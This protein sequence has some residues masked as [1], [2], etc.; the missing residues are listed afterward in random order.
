[1]KKLLISLL[2]ISAMLLCACGG[3]NSKETTAHDTTAKVPE[4]AD[5][6]ETVCDFSTVEVSGYV[7]ATVGET[8]KG[9]ED[10]AGAD[11]YQLQKPEI[12]SITGDKSLEIKSRGVTLVGYAKEGKTAA[13][14]LCAF[15][16]GEGPDRTAGEPQLFE[17]GD[18]FMHTAPIGGVEYLSID[19]RV[20]DVGNAPMLSFK[21]SGYAVVTCANASR[22]FLYSF[23]VY[24]RD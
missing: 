22:P 18:T 13:Y 24:D 8:V 2:L 9:H 17:A 10:A 12:A 5:G 7:F 6:K 21:E 16:E 3:N 15:A 11:A 14:V 20:V 23:I 19:S 4:K 1:M